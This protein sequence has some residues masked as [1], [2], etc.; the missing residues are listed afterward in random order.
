MS[1][2]NTH[3]AI[4]HVIHVMHWENKGVNKI[5]EPILIPAKLEAFTCQHVILLASK[6]IAGNFA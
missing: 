6:T 2:R 3:A 1:R 5:G 4:R